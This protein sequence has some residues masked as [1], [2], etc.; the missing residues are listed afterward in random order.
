MD[1]I[2]SENIE[3][4]LLLRAIYLKYGY[5]FRNY[6]RSSL[7]RRIRESMIKSGI[8]AMS[9]VQHRLLYDRSFFSSL[10]RDLSVHVTEMFRDP[11]VYKA[12]RNNVLPK[13]KKL[14]V[15]RIW[16]AGCAT[17]EEVYSM[18]IILKEEGLYDKSRIFA[19]DFDETVLVTAKEGVYPVEKIKDY[20]SNYLESGGLGSLADHYYA[21][22]GFILIDKDLKKNILFS[23]HNLVTDN[24]F[25]EMD[26]IICRNVLIY[27]NS[28]LQHRVFRLF[29]ESLRK[30]GFLCLGAKETIRLSPSSESFTDFCKE[31]R[32]YR[33]M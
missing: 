7:K 24:S 13:L 15:I 9:E 28:E 16:H 29:Y 19:T 1:T 4:E 26:V 30:K 27:F 8:N 25:G 11:F 33:K 22:Y 3:L 6:T 21:K 12:M 17:G 20:T 23:N 18:A 2:E 31:E 5:D 14:P 32:I 10:L